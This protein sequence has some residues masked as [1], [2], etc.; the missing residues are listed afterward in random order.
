MNR[1]AYVNPG[2]YSGTAAK[3]MKIAV[4]LLEMKNISREAVW[5]EAGQQFFHSENS[6]RPKREGW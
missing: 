6:I 1:L 4:L 2:K 5:S 3:I